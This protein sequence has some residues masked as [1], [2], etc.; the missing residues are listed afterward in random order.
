MSKTEP[1]HGDTL[2][3]TAAAQ[4]QAKALWDELKSKKEEEWTNNGCTEWSADTTVLEKELE[5]IATDWGIV[6]WTKDVRLWCLFG[7]WLTAC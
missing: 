4:T 7:V 5:K 2:P 6:S 3:L 1:K